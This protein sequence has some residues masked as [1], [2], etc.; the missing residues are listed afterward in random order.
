MAKLYRTILADPPWPESGAGK[1]KRGADRHYPLMSVDEIAAVKIPADMNAHL[2][3]WVTNNYFEAGF[4]VIYAWGFRPITMISWF[5]TGGRIGLGRYFRGD[6]EH[7]MFAVR[8]NLPYKRENG[9][10]V[11]RPTSILAPRREHSRKPD[12]IYDYAEA[13][14]YAPRLELFSRH[15][16]AGWD[17]T[18][19]DADGKDIRETP[20]LFGEEKPCRKD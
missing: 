1:I 14:S 13:I 9:K 16:R 5:K 8:G 20:L 2:Y 4:R 19:F 11:W 15:A 17:A 12:D 7:C 18:G 6:T 10:M 3:L